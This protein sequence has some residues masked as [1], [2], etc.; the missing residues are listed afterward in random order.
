[1]EQWR[2]DLRQFIAD[3]GLSLADFCRRYNYKPST[4][5]DY[6]N[7]KLPAIRVT[8]GRIDKLMRIIGG[9]QGQTISIEGRTPV[10]AG[11]ISSA[12]MTAFADNVR[13]TGKSFINFVI[14]STPEERETLR[15]LL[16]PSLEDLLDGSRGMY[17]ENSR[18]QV[19]T[20]RKK[21]H[22]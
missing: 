1:M 4:I 7:E 3:Q 5:S 2:K 10:C 6:C 17:S 16:G 22:G 19:I 12:A 20:E 14:D 8:K 21:R 11:T 9:Q 18:A 13:A 15:R